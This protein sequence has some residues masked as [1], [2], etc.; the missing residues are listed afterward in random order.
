M[1][2]EELRKQLAQQ[3][4]KNEATELKEAERQQKA[5]KSHKDEIQA[6]KRAKNQLMVRFPFCDNGITVN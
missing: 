6:L 5:K 3:R 4:A 1:E 2:N